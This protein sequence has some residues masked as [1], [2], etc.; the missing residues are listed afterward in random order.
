MARKECLQHLANVDLFR[1]LSARELRAVADQGKDIEY[2]EGTKVAVEGEEGGRFHVILE[3]KATVGRRG[4]VVAT[5]GPGDYF[6]EIA[7]IDGGPRTATVTA[8]PPLR[9]HSIARFNFRPLL[10]EYPGITEKLLVEVA[11][12]LRGLG[13]VSY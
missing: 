7:L 13:G 6:G 3:G 8:E 4:K 12:R 11:R 10:R 1:G 5:L 9:T 2:R